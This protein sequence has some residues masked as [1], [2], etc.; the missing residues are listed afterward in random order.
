MWVVKNRT[1]YAIFKETILIV[2]TYSNS[3]KGKAGK[4]FYWMLCVLINAILWYVEAC[5]K[6]SKNYLWRS[7]LLRDL[8]L[9]ELLKGIV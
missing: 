7:S 4:T 1:L 6:K 9:S 2:C 5:D 8:I 3:G